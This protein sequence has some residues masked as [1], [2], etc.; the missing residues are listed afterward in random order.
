[1]TVFD[2]LLLAII[3]ISVAFAAA[4][5]AVKELATLAALAF[6]G[7]GAWVGVPPA[8][9]MIGK[10]GSFFATVLVAGAIV[11]VVFLAIYFL[12][13]KGM[14]RIKLSK[15]QKMADR[16][17]GGVYGFFRALAL[18]GLG[19]LGYGYYLDEPNQ[20]EAV[21]GAMLLPLA[22]A[23]AGF[24]E[25]MAPKTE[26]L[27]PSADDADDETPASAASEGYDRRDRAGLEEIVTTMTTNDRPAKSASGDPIA[28]ILA[29][30][31]DGD[32]QPQPGR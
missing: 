5:G 8:L 16:V 6:A 15:K 22:S 10:T 29:K 25:R 31:T 20:P 19:F 11:V 28:D 27:Q 18:I 1:M 3:G 30:E 26:E 24:F 2:A 9:A 17:G 13:H 14:S 32:D 7:L 12:T 23:T 21:R 4:R